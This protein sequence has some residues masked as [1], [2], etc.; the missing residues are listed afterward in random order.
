MKKLINKTDDVVKEQMEGMALAHPSLK[1]NLDPKYIYR[2]DAPIDKKVAVISGGGSGHEPMHGGFVGEGM[3]DAAC[4]GEV[5]T[6]P[7]P[8]QMHSCGKAVDSGAGV[9]FLVKNYTGDVMNFEMA[10][11][12]LHGE[13]VPVQNVI[14]DD[15]VAVKD[16]LYTAGRR[17]VGTTVIME[18]IVGAAA[19][20]GY[21]LDQCT[22]LAMKVNRHGRSMGMALTSCTVPAAGKPT[23][24]LEENM[25]EIGVGIHGEPGRKRIEHTSADEITNILTKGILDDGDYTRQL[26]TMNR[27]SGTW[28]EVEQVNPALKSG[29]EVIAMVNGLGGTPVSELYAVYRQMA[30]ICDERGIRIVRNLVGNYITALEMQGCSI[31][32][33]KVDEEMLKFWDAPVNTPGLRWGV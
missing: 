5:F 33:V 6:S 25:I 11:E 3:L 13:G 4:P 15:D 27:E 10:A 19:K 20:A 14:I 17:G 7:T 24:D 22:E 21:N 8:D 18:K 29:D 1:I 23:F 28:E 32:L 16:S 9:L 31:T 12:L 2:A 30:K 26:K